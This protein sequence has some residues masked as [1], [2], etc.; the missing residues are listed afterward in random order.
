MRYFCCLWLLLVGLMAVGDAL[1]ATFAVNA[2]ADDADA[3][4]VSP[5]D[6]AC[7]DNFGACT[8]RAALMETNALA[9]DDAIEFSVSGTITITPTLGPLPVITDFLIIDGQTAP[10]FNT[11]TNILLDAPPQIIINGNQLTGSVSD[12]LRFSG[13]AAADSQLLSLSVVNFPDNGVEILTDTDGIIIQGCSLSGNGGAGLFAVNPDFMVIGQIYGIF[14]QEFLGLGNLISSNGEA[15]ISLVSSDSNIIFG[16]FIGMLADGVTVAGNS[17]TGINLIGNNN[18]IGFGDEDERGGNIVASNSGDG[19]SVLGNDNSIGA[20]RIGLGSV[21][22]FFG[23]VGNGINVSGSNNYIGGQVVNMRNDIANNLTGIRVG[24]TGGSAGDGTTIE[25]N[26]IGIA[27]GAL[28]NADDGIRV[29]R[30]DNVRILNNRVINNAGNGIMTMGNDTIIRGNSIGVLGSSRFGNAEHGIFTFAALRAIIGGNNAGDAN[31]IGDNGANVAPFFHGLQ[32]QGNEHQIIGNYIGITPNGS[33]IGQPSIGLALATSFTTVENNT[34]GFNRSGV[35]LGGGNNTIADNHIGTNRS[36]AN[37]GNEFDGL[38]L[39]GNSGGL[40][41]FIGTNNVI[42]YNGRFGISGNAIPGDTTRYNIIGNRVLQNGNTGMAIPFNGSNGSYLVQFNQIAF[43]GNRGITVLG[44]DTNNAITAN[45]MY[46]NN[47]LAID[48]AGDGQSANDP[49][50]PDSGPNRRMNYPD[51]LTSVFI[52]GSPSAV[53]V[54]FRVDTTAANATYPL[55]VQ[56][57]WTDREEPM[58]GRFFLTSVEYASPQAIQNNVFTLPAFATTGGKLALMV[59]DS[60][61]NSSELSPSVTFGQIELLLRD[62]FETFNA[63]F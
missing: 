49:G 29:E 9:T 33:D 22:G 46:G 52:P 32:I 54:D 38:I 35:S 28:G 11:G 26:N 8:L 31:I 36:G 53:S 39:Q 48:L 47:G 41:N 63:D 56:A 43:N 62:G 34:V 4:D 17:G 27:A 20:N 12:G 60:D 44:N 57:F 25:N 40:N 42:A 1:A 51:I 10:G 19:I 55:T 3:E 6:G 13:T 15:G 30:G 7:A 45:T 59:T 5:G 58:Q 21:D 23:N 61:G 14:T 37:A 18:L 2:L 50:D 24:F 16:N